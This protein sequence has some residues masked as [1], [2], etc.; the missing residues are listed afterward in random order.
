M[1][2]VTWKEALAN[3]KFITH[4]SFW[5]AGLA[6]FVLPLPYYFNNIIQPKPGSLLIDPFHGFLEPTNWSREIFVLIFVAPALFLLNNFKSPRTM[7]LTLQCYVSVNLMRMSTVYLFTLE[8]PE[9]IIPLVDPFLTKVVYGNNLFVKD[10]FFSGHTCTIFILFL[11]EQK[12][13]LKVVLGL[14]TAAVA[15]FLVWQR[16]HYTIDILGAI[17]ACILVYQFFI[18]SIDK[19]DWK[20]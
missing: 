12:R 9:G 18:R 16:V 6:I 13:W 4:I 11:I 19:I 10:L 20:K 7:L 1:M 2:P 8:A 3:R 17:L 15:L 5:L 14:S